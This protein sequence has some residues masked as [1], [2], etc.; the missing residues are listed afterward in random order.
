MLQLSAPMALKKPEF[1]E[2]LFPFLVMDVICFS[3]NHNITIITEE[4]KT[5]SSMSL[6]AYL[7]YNFRYTACFLPVLLPNK[8]ISLSLGLLF[9]WLRKYI[10]TET[11][12][13]KESIQLI[14]HTLNVLR[15][16]SVAQGTT[17][18]GRHLKTKKNIIFSRRGTRRRQSAILGYRLMER[19]QLFNHCSSSSEVC[20]CRSEREKFSYCTPHRCSA[21]L[22]SL[23]YV[24]LWC[25]KRMGQLQLPQDESYSHFL[26]IYQSVELA[27][28]HSTKIKEENY[29]ELL[30]EI[31]SNINEPDSIYGLQ[32]S[33]RCAQ[34]ELG[35]HVVRAC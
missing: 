9:P 21:Y 18:K 26:K 33:Q 24:E 20:H 12:T 32:R 8:R 19:F 34:I 27:D 22:T 1:A 35:L 14:L 2:F 28:P 5:A 29:M 17:L 11:N 23:L 4:S 25:E 15:K 31:Y 30:L 7:S 13:N 6:S 10:F 3:R 16:Q